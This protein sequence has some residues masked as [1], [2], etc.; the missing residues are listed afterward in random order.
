MANDD[1]L[2]I[3]LLMMTSLVPEFDG[4]NIPVYEYSKGLRDVK[5]LVAE[6]DEPLSTR[7]LQ[8]KLRGLAYD[9]IAFDGFNNIHELMKRIRDWFRSS[10]DIY[11]LYAKLMH[12]Y[13]QPN[14]SVIDYTVRL[15]DLIDRIKDLDEFM[16]PQRC[17]TKEHFERQV[18]DNGLKELIRG[19]KLR[20]KIFMRQQSL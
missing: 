19:L 11:D 10:E 8:I 14:E 16:Q 20:I 1:R 12:L 9:L 15:E 4:K 5:R 7:I 17:L 18:D 3:P 6:E 13:Q 2:K